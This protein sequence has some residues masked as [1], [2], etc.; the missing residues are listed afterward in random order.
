MI[1]AVVFDF[2][3]TLVHTYENGMD[4]LRIIAQRIGLPLPSKKSLKE[5]YGKSWKDFVST[6][7]PEMDIESFSEKYF[8]LATQLKPS[9]PVHGVHEI[10]DIL[11]KK[12]VL[13][14]VTGNEKNAFLQ[15][16]MQAGIAFSK[17]HFML[18]ENDIRKSKGDPSYFDPMVNELSRLGIKKNEVL[19]VGDSIH[20]YE[21]AKKAGISFVGVLTGLSTRSDLVAE[22]LRE[23][24][25][26]PSV[27][28]LPHL[29]ENNGF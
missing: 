13:G 21:T 4:N 23:R 11:S 15:K 28:E 5:H 19:F 6:M 10:L 27:M 3:D 17:F 1:K 29:I 14:I 9:P 8:S 12:F 2:D 24:M 7:W 25:I 20:D 18:A 22:G 16:L 26:I